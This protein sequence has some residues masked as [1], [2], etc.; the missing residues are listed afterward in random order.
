MLK[1]SAIQRDA[2]YTL[3]RA[4]ASRSKP[5]ICSSLNRLFLTPILLCL[6]KENFDST[7][8]QFS[9]GGPERRSVV[10]SRCLAVRVS[11]GLRSGA[12]ASTSC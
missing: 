2:R 10:S 4:S 7:Q 6:A 11:G 1:R 8:G 9:R 5:M 3:R 12:S